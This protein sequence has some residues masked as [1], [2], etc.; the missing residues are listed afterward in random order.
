MNQP[1]SGVCPEH[2]RQHD[3]MHQKR[4]GHAEGDDVGQRIELA[5]ERAFGPA[6]ARHPAVEQIEDAGQQNEEERDAG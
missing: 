6:H 4:R 3:A 5:T 1:I 2:F